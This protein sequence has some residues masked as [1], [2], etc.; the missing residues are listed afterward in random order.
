MSHSE[1]PD[2][3][4]RSDSPVCSNR[5]SDGEMSDAESERTRRPERTVNTDPRTVGFTYG[6]DKENIRTKGTEFKQQFGETVFIKY[7]TPMGAAFG[8]W[9]ILSRS[10]EAL[11]A[12]ESWLRDQEQTCLRA[13]N[14]GSYVPRA[15]RPEL[16]EPQR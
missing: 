5:H 6:K 14:D 2:Q 9:K 8:Y 4:S 7:V 11:S 13:I 1:T 16:S 10:E 12:A 15:R 3:R